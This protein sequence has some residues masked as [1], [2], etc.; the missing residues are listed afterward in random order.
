M[1]CVL[2]IVLS[3][4]V[5]SDSANPRTIACQAPLSLGFSRQEYWS[6]HA[7]LQGTFPTQGSNPCLPHCRQILFCLSHQGSPNSALLSLK[8]VLRLKPSHIMTGLLQGCNPSIDFAICLDEVFVFFWF[9]W[10]FLSFPLPCWSQN[11]SQPFLNTSLACDTTP[12][13]YLNHWSLWGILSCL[14]LTENW[15]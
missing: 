7:L 6:C 12:K 4:S 1:P 8:Y 13:N 10:K 14:L 15:Q 5:M 11:M 9:L 2:C 3:C